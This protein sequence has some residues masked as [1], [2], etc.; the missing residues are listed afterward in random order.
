MTNEEM[1]EVRVPLTDF[2]R[3]VAQE[4]AVIAAKAV[5]DEYRVNCPMRPRVEVIEAAQ[6]VVARSRST[7]AK[8]IWGVAQVA[9]AVTLG[10]LLA[11]WQ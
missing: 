1:N 8:R 7:L 6:A 9:F 3:G 11:K 4:A 10:W 2:V 5:V